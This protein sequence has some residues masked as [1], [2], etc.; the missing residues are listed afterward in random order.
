MKHLLSGIPIN[1][2]RFFWLVLICADYVALFNCTILF[3]SSLVKTLFIIWLSHIIT[4]HL[5]ANVEM[6]TK[7]EDLIIILKL[8]VAGMNNA[9]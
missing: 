4:V 5:K 2:F 8:G 6:K 3:S 1:L 9:T 7:E